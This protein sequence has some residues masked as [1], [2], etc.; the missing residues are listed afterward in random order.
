VRV[1]VKKL[2]QIITETADKFI[3]KIG[4]ADKYE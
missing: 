2:Q 3:G 4:R 1:V